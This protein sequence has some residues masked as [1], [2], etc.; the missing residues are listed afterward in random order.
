MVL[1]CLIP[2][3]LPC[4]HLIAG[5]DVYAPLEIFHDFVQVACSGSTE[6]AC[7]AVRLGEKEKTFSQLLIKQRHVEDEKTRMIILQGR[8]Y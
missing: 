4:S 8:K 1:L 2:S 6:E 3:Q 5:I 7:I